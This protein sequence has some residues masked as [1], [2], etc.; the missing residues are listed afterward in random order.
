MQTF[1]TRIN[2]LKSLRGY[3]N[4]NITIKN[5]KSTFKESRNDLKLPLPR[6]VQVQ[7]FTI[8]N[9]IRIQ[10]CS[11]MKSY[12]ATLYKCIKL[13]FS[14]LYNMLHCLCNVFFSQKSI[15][16]INNFNFFCGR[17]LNF[18]QA[19]IVVFTHNNYAKA[20]YCIIILTLQVWWTIAQL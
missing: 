11:W 19:H 16:M 5:N 15:L 4:N 10:D 3:G 6:R 2:R 14:H 1:I 18:T 12:F 13:C 7:C 17:P 8:Q 20:R 9:L